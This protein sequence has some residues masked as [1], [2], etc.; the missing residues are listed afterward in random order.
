[1][2]ESTALRG[3]HDLNQ[4]LLHFDKRRLLSFQLCK[5]MR[6]SF[7]PAQFSTSTRSRLSCK[8][9]IQAATKMHLNPWFSMSSMP[10]TASSKEARKNLE[11]GQEMREG[12]AEAVKKPLDNDRS[13]LTSEAHNNLRADSAM[14]E[15]RAREQEVRSHSCMNRHFCVISL[16]LSASIVRFLNM[17]VTLSY[18]CLLTLQVKGKGKL[19]NSSSEVLRRSNRLKRNQEVSHSRMKETNIMSFQGRQLANTSGTYKQGHTDRSKQPETLAV[20]I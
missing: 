6:K 7:K 16:Q 19:H 10:N 14:R 15:D 5:S 4:V 17:Q 2:S 11:A 9:I 8:D 1:M 12:A 18:R 13:S 20:T 3:S